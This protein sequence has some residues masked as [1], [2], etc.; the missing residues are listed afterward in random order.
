ML[1]TKEEIKSDPVMAIKM[2]YVDAIERVFY[3]LRGAIDQPNFLTEKII[4][5]IQIARGIGEDEILSGQ[6]I[7]AEQDLTFDLEEIFKYVL[8]DDRLQPDPSMKLQLDAFLIKRYFSKLEQPM[9]DN[10][11]ELLKQRLTYVIK[12]MELNFERQNYK[13]DR[14]LKFINYLQT[15]TDKRIS[16]FEGV[17]NALKVNRF[18]CKSW[19]AKLTINKEEI[20]EMIRDVYFVEA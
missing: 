14:V 13:Y 1:P 19:S 11:M 10:L 12:M 5:R 8:E 20:N 6:A 15:V 18:I 2:Q 16:I 9:Q 17:F 4:Q 3:H 7:E